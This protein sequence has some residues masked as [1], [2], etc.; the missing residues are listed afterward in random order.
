MWDFRGNELIGAQEIQLVQEMSKAKN[1]RAIF[2]HAVVSVEPKQIDTLF[3]R[4]K[5]VGSL[6]LSFSDRVS[7]ILAIQVFYRNGRTNEMTTNIILLVLPV[8]IY[9]SMPLISRTLT[10]QFLILFQLKL[11]IEGYSCIKKNEQSKVFMAMKVI[12]SITR[13]LPS[14]IL[15]LVTLLAS[16]NTLKSESINLL[17]SILISVLGTAWTVNTSGESISMLSSGFLSTMVFAIS[18]ITFRLLSLSIMFVTI[19]KY[20]YLVL[21]LEL[22]IRFYLVAVSNEFREERIGKSYF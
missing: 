9:S 11:V 18:E 2:E 7:D 19:G 22:L 3:G 15:Q 4:G 16:F 20:G 8:L 14:A 10:D 6:F 1:A 5:L 17:V 13:S 21:G 12:D